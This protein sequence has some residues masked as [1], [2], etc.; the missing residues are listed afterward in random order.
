MEEYSEAK[1]LKSKPELRNN[2][3]NADYFYS[4]AKIFESVARHAVFVYNK[5]WINRHASTDICA[6]SSVR[7]LDVTHY[8][9]LNFK[10]SL[11]ALKLPVKV[12]MSC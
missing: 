2:N 12:K 11:Y 9:T 8:D 3:R 5:P 10:I 1:T 7:I 6:A 4:S